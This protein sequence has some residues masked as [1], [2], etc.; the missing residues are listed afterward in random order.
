MAEFSSAAFALIKEF[1]NQNIF[2]G[3]SK[4]YFEIKLSNIVQDVSFGS[5]LD[6]SLQ[7]V[8]VEKIIKRMNR[9]LKYKPLALTRTPTNKDLATSKAL[10]K[11]REK[12][13]AYY[14]NPAK[15]KVQVYVKNTHPRLKRFPEQYDKLNWKENKRALLSSDTYLRKKNIEQFEKDIVDFF[16]NFTWK[17]IKQTRIDELVPKS[18]T[19]IRMV[20][21]EIWSDNESESLKP[22]VEDLEPYVGIEVECLSKINKEKLVKHLVDKAPLLYKYVRIGYDG[23]IRTSET[24]PFAFEFRILCKQ[25]DVEKITTRFFE[26][27]K[28]IIK[29]NNSCGL[30]VHLDMRNRKFGRSYERLYMSLPVLASM[31]PASRRESNTYCKL[32]TNKSGWQSN[33]SDRYLAINPVSYRKYKTLEVRMHSA[34]TNA[35]KV[36]NWVKLLTLII[37]KEFSVNKEG[38]SL[39]PQRTLSSLLSFFTKYEVPSDLR[40]YVTQRIAKFGKYKTLNIPKE[41][42]GI[43]PSDN[44]YVSVEQDEQDDN[45]TS[46]AV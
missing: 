37:D 41:L 21:S 43:I 26:V 12:L 6:S 33:T 2:K 18:L 20:A 34:T 10:S 28:D 35:K 24:H 7:I 11:A 32:N 15:V 30:H 16:E 44:T 40:N 39:E 42:E 25:S 38:K 27:L 17:D 8:I 22:R 3:K 14:D 1:K 45:Q 23:S 29:V 46:V 5:D 31:I 36:T 13:R 19:K 9:K 4:E